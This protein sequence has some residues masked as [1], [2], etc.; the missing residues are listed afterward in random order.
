VE[1]IMPFLSIQLV[2]DK[3]NALAVSR[4]LGEGFQ[5][6]GV[7]KMAAREVA[8]VLRRV[9]ETHERG[10]ELVL[11]LATN[12]YFKDTIHGVLGGSTSVPKEAI[13]EAV[14]KAFEGVEDKAKLVDKDVIA[15]IAYEEV[16]GRLGE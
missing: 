13:D 9:P 15:E 1:L 14:I 10:P 12:R 3:D 16:A 11:R 2:D 5:Y 8:E 4:S 6:F 7:E